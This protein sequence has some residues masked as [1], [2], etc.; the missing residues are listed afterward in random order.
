VDGFDGPLDLL[1][2][3]ARAQQIDL[4]RLSI[5][6]LIE[7]FTDALQAALAERA[8][9][10]LEHWAVWTVMAASL[11]ELWS[12]LKLPPSA[13]EARAA[14]AE[15]EALRRRLISRAEIEAAATWLEQRPHLGQDVFRRGQPRPNADAA[16][17]GGDLSDLLRA[18]LP[19]LR[20]P[21]AQA[22]ALHPRPPP[23]WTAT[24]AIRRIARLLDE[25]PNGSPLAA[26][27]PKIDR[28]APKRP[29]RC[30]AAIASTLIASLELARD[31]TVALEQDGDWMP[32]RARLTSGSGSADAPDGGADII[33]HQQP[34][35][36]MELAASLLCGRPQASLAEIGNRGADQERLSPPSLPDRGPYT[37]N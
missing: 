3:L 23:L 35:A 20:V 8:A 30:R 31:S 17:R 22:I 19:V 36:G 26:F 21:E 24:D 9:A 2:V 16:A 29:L 6:A 27:L 11:T 28:D 18:C 13:P 33:G 34:A 7:A 10:R 5:A 1:L 15:A 37:S 4:A 32:I 12:R 14:A 25:L